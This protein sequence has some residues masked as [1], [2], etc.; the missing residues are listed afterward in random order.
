MSV[1]VAIFMLVLVRSTM[2]SGMLSSVLAWVFLSLIL[3][4]TLSI[5]LGV[6]GA[7]GLGS[8]RKYFCCRSGGDP[9]SF[10]YLGHLICPM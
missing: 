9:S 7:G 1:S 8:K 6:G 2:V 5:G 3:F 4:H 10:G